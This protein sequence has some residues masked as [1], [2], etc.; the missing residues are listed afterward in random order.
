MLKGDPQRENLDGIND[1]VKCAGT[2][3]QRLF[4]IADHAEP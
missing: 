3:T 1:A 2:L 4:M